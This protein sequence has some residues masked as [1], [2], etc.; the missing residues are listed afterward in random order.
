MSIYGN[1]MPNQIYPKFDY[2]QQSSNLLSNL[3]N[4]AAYKKN[5]DL[6]NLSNVNIFNN[7]NFGDQTFGINQSESLFP[8]NNFDMNGAMQTNYQNPMTQQS[9]NPMFPQQPQQNDIFTML[10]QILN[11]LL[12]SLMDNGNQPENKQPITKEKES[13]D[14]KPKKDNQQVNVADNSKGVWGD[15]HYNVVGANGKDVNFDHK[16]VEG[17]TY[18]VFKGDGYVI[19]GKYSRRNTNNPDEYCI[20]GDTRIKTGG[21]T[22]GYNLEG[23]TTL[24]GK[25]L[26]EGSHSLS[27]GTKLTI[28]GPTLTLHSKEGDSKV[29]LTNSDGICIDP[30]GKFSGMD[31][32]LGT[33]IAK[34]KVLSEEESNRFDVSSKRGF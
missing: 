28:N 33:A 30:S 31:G 32:I 11:L 25:E 12:S 7:Y 14:I 5:Q 6:F 29:T 16:G 2:S 4:G 13:V 19:D 21:G 1:I 20:I 9:S 17:H 24:N 23:K 15:P 26:K 18:N 10:Q 22:V 27:D 8:M 34:S 3:Q